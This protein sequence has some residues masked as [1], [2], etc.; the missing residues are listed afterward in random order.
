[1]YNNYTLEKGILQ[2]VSL[3]GKEKP[4]KDKKSK[5]LLLA[6]SY[7]RLGKIKKY[8]KVKYCGSRLLFAECKEHNYK[9]LLAADF[10]RNRLC[11]MCNWRRSRMLAK[12]IMEILHSA[13]F[14][15]PMKFIF[16]TLTIQNCKGNELPQTI[17]K[18]FKGFKRLFE[19]K[20]VKDNVVGYVRVLE[21]T[22]NVNKY[23]KSYNTYHPHFHV[24]IGVKSTYFKNKYIKHSEWVRLW[25]KALRIDYEPT[26]NVKR[27]KP[28]KEGQDVE[29]AVLETGKYAVK[30]SDYILDDKIET[31]K[32]VAVLDKALKGRRL[33]GFGKFFR[34]VKKELNIGDVESSTADLV[35]N[36]EEQ[37]CKC[38]IC[39]SNLKE[40]LYQW[41]YGLNNYYKEDKI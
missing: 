21:I 37:E 38:P 14:L 28:K 12:Q 41:H 2:D 18:L 39:Q 13:N 19:L 25:Q 7:K 26:V 40:T 3:Y 11:P 22:H 33:I 10:C 29:S 24:L 4:W 20:A 31:D 16:L 8:Y 1:M 35:G 36:N 32:A 27:V 30:D 5:S 15:K 9:K 34:E 17:D 23:S 6:D